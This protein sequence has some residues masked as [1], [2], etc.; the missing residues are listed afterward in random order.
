MAELHY[1]NSLLVKDVI[2]GMS[3]GLTVPFALTA[4]LSGVLNTNHLIIVSGLAEITAGCISMGLG[5]YLAGQSEVEHYDSELKGELDE[6]ETVPATELK[7]V[8]DI[9]IAMGV[10]TLLS[11]QVALQVSRDK[12]IWANFMMQLELNMEKPANNRA[13][14]SA[15]TIALAYL[16]GGF[17][18]LSPYILIK[19]NTTGFYVS[20]IATISA[21]LFFGY[22]KSKV[23][24]QPL[25]KGTLKVTLTGIIA[26][27]AAFLLAKAVS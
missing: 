10:D 3:D 2:I 18:P 6:I 20:C 27:G 19:D 8:E 23:T 21:L 13:A 17:I 25:L 26:A 5:G 4:G 11:K 1:K 16:V 7:E 15:G 12:N 24:G 14:K 22:F 9:L